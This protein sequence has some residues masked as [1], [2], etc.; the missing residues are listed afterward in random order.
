MNLLIKGGRVFDSEAGLDGNYDILIKGRNFAKIEKKITPDET[1]QVVNLNGELVLPGFIDMHVHLREPGRVDKETILTGTKAALYGGFT[2]VC[3]M[4]NTDPVMD[5][6]TG[7]EFYSKAFGKTPIPI[8][9][10]ACISKKQEGKEITQMA[11][12]FS[13]GA[14]GFS[15]DGKPVDNSELMR[16]ALEYSKIIQ[17]PI[18]SHCE[19]TNLAKDGVMNE[20]Y[21]ST[22]LGLK[23]YPAVAEEVMVSRDILLAELTGGKLHLAHLST[24]KSV[25]LLKNAKRKNLNVTGEVTINH[26]LLNDSDLV[27]YDT[28]YKI[29]PPLRSKADSSSLLRGIKNETID[30]L[31]SDHAPHTAEEKEVEFN[32]APFGISGVETLVS[33][34]FTEFVLKD[35][36]DLNDAVRILAKNPA[37]ILNLPERII[38]ENYQANLTI[39]DTNVSKTIDK[40]QFHSKGKN[41]PYHGWQINAIPVKT[42]VQGRLYDL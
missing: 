13:A 16:C 18:V 23:G 1:C 29:N 20:G 31:V 6:E 38:K 40:N 9:P 21:Y 14:V 36:V 8:Y 24:E 34:F 37:R 27:S 32:I 28:N 7:V 12:L 35:K 19:D 3:A 4:G 15:D 25:E 22:L 41:T 10:I 39:I 33:L 2:A 5:E 30:C 11:A 42:V 17:A 26:L